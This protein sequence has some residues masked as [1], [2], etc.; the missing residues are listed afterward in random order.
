[1]QAPI[2]ILGIDL[3]IHRPVKDSSLY[4]N[5]PITLLDKGWSISDPTTGLLIKTNTGTIKELIEEATEML[6]SIGKERV[7][8]TIS[9]MQERIA[10]W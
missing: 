2:S 4:P 10:I 6:S 7:L 5:D 1:M 3:S 9:N 8:A